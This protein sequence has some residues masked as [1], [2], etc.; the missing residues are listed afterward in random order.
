MYFSLSLHTSSCRFAARIKRSS[1][2]SKLPKANSWSLPSG[3]QAVS[4]YRTVFPFGQHAAAEPTCMICTGASTSGGA[5]NANANP[6]EASMIGAEQTAT[7][8]ATP[9]SEA[10]NFAT[11]GDM[12][13]RATV[14]ASGGRYCSQTKKM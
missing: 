10:A 11:S 4:K 6:S 2:A 12:R 8:W 3:A 7:K 9:S 14:R 1:V 5:A 13:R